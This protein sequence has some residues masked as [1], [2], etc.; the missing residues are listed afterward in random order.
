MIFHL[1]IPQNSSHSKTVLTSVAIEAST[2]NQH[3]TYGKN[4]ILLFLPNPVKYAYWEPQMSLF[5][6]L[7]IKPFITLYLRILCRYT[8]IFITLYRYSCVPCL[9]P[10]FMLMFL[11][12]A[13]FLILIVVYITTY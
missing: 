9:L 6:F 12:T 11:I 2:L 8:R 1:F 5:I 13:I 7:Q 3:F 4:C 10:T